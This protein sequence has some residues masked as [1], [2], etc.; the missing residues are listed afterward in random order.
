MSFFPEKLHTHTFYEMDIFLGGQISYIVSDHEVFPQRGGIL[1]VPPGIT[2]T[3]RQLEKSEYNR[4][5]FYFDSKAFDFLGPGSLPAFFYEPDAGYF[6]VKDE[7]QA[8]FH[9]L[10]EQIRYTLE[11]PCEGVTLLSFTYILQLFLLIARHSQSDREHFSKLPLK[12]LQI[13]TYIDQNYQTITST[14]EVASHFFYSREYVSRIFKQYFNTN[15]SEYITRKKI[16]NAKQALENGQ[17][18]TQAFSVSGYRSMSAFI[19]A[20]R[21]ITSMSP[22]DF[23]RQAMLPSE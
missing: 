15:L 8:Q 17:S 6:S 11:H 2:H 7:F 5:V 4:I 9:Y 14:A 12:V 23:R 19:A 18:V 1:F 13:K 16:E 3:A 21:S 10:L 20:F 22:S